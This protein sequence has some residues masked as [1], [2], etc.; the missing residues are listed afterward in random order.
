MN[1]PIA[2]S[3][4]INNKS[5]IIYQEYKNKFSEIVNTALKQFILPENIDPETF[6]F[7]EFL[8]KITEDYQN[9]NEFLEQLKNLN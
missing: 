4:F 8:N 7:K 2:L 1:N 5:Y 6:D 9:D 3:Y